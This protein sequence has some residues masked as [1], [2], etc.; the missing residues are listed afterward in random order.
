MS[1]H[2]KLQDAVSRMRIADVILKAIDASLSDGFVPEISLESDDVSFQLLTPIC[3]SV[4]S[5]EGQEA[6][7]GRRRTIFEMHAGLRVLAPRDAGYSD[8]PSDEIEKFICAR[9]ECQ[10]L[11]SYD[12]AQG[13]G[14]YIDDECLAL[15]AEHNVPF[16]MWPYWREIV[17]SACGRMGL[18]RIILPT[19]RLH[20]S[21]TQKADASLRVGPKPLADF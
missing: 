8:L 4:N 11:V 17:Q 1:L 14:S 19:H 6:D 2:P 7:A 13:D 16:N 10:F 12:E 20:K 3:R 15:F 21:A 18:P 9:I 5:Y